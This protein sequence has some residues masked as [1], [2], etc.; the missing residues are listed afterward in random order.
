MDAVLD[1]AQEILDRIAA[2]EIE[3]ARIEAATAADMLELADLRRRQGEG[4]VSLE[5]RR[6]RATYASD[7]SPRCCSTLPARCRTGWR[8][9]AGFAGSCR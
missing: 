5:R 6:L 2:R 9:P 7:G 8:R 4:D 1:P 3:R